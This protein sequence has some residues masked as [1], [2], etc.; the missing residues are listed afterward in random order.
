MPS[1][2]I[3]I[4]LGHHVPSIGIIMF[5]HVPPVD[6]IMFRVY[7]QIYKEINMDTKQYSILVMGTVE[8]RVIVSGA[9]L[10]EAEANAY[11]EWSALTGGHIGTAESV[12]AHEVHPELAETAKRNLD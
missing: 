2:L 12:E 11:S 6:S 3:F 8:R 9:S 4:F 1:Y 10:A 5:R 7:K